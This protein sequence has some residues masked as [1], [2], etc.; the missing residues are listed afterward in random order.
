M[1]IMSPDNFKSDFEYIQKSCKFDIMV[2]D[3]GHRAKNISTKFRKALKDF[4]VKVQ[5]IVLTGTPVQNNLSE[6]YSILDLVSDNIFG[7][8]K[9]FKEVYAQPIK[10]GLQ[11]YAKFNQK[12]KA[13]ELI[14]VLK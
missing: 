13:I 10:K 1:V 8:E 5:K 3:E 12:R 6:F 2:I 11:K 7:T 9:N 4:Q 14:K